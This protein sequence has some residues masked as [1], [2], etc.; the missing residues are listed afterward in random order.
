MHEFSLA[1]KALMDQM[2]SELIPKYKKYLVDFISDESL[3]LEERW[4]IWRKAPDCLKEHQS[5]VIDEFIDPQTGKELNFMDMFY[6]ERY[7]T[8]KLDYLVDIVQ[9]GSR[10][11]L[12]P[13]IQ[14]YALKNNLGSF[15]YDW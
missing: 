13:I 9:G 11:Y 4:N 8:V 14:T 10:D 2:K 15:V 3:P 1:T 6:R 12:V 7:Q 5:W